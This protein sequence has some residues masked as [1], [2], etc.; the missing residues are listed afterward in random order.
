M[1][2]IKKFHQYLWGRHFLLQ[3]DH[4]PLVK[5]FGSKKGLPTTAANRL[6]NYAIT[7]MAYSF[8]IEYVNTLKF[9]KADGLSRLPSG[10][11]VD[12][13]PMMKKIDCAIVDIYTKTFS[14]LP[15][16]AA[17]V[18]AATAT[19]QT[20]QAVM[21]LHRKGWPDHL[22]K[23][24]KPVGLNVQVDD[25]MPFFRIRHQLAIANDCLLWG[26]R[27]LIPKSLRPRVLSQ[28][29]KTHPGQSM[30]KRLAHKHF[31]WPGLDKDVAQLV[32][33]CEACR[34][35]LNDTPKV[36][37]QPWPVAER[38]WKRIHIDFA[39]PF[40]DAMWFIV[41]DAY[42]K[43]PGV[44]QMKVGK[45]TTMDVVNALSEM[46][47]RYGIAEEIVSDNG[48]Q[49]TSEDF[50]QWCSQQG[51]RHIRSAPYQPQ[52]NG[53]AERFVQTFK[54]AMLKSTGEGERKEDI[55]RR[56]LLFLQRYRI[57]PHPSTDQAPAERFL[58]REPRT[59]WNLM[60][61]D[62]LA[63]LEK[64]RAK[65]KLHF[66]EHECTKAKDELTVGAT[67]FARV[68]RGKD[69]W[70]QATIIQKKGSVMWLIKVAGS[71]K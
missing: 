62:D 21:A 8:D 49:F 31:W 18:R 33:A 68:Y 69:K 20:F 9:G 26:L 58:K 40:L 29:H 6:Q 70:V 17:D 50:Q 63:P 61:G 45:T 28:L 24:F 41:V 25:L 53:Q 5:I 51:I 39:G 57:T 46:F 36:P 38:P 2:G 12:F 56:L 71:E 44:I 67:V 64:A 11:D 16:S 43:W 54:N 15:V 65:M 37:L 10:E 42:S 27:V 22:S 32:T 13:Q 14:T 30:M 55:R 3:T 7:L 47:S 59:Q 34:S 1:F 4:Q 35:V 23:G 48:T 60:Y 19:D 52:S 66:D